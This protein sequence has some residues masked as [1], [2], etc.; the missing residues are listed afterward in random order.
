LLE[1][2]GACLL[3]PAECLACS[4]FEPPRMPIFWMAQPCAAWPQLAIRPMTG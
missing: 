1:A 4:C 3:S 2:H